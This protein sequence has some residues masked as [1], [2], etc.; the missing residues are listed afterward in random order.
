MK[1]V[2]LYE[3]AQA[4]KVIVHLSLGYIRPNLEVLSQP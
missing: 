4:E 3:V 1:K 2:L